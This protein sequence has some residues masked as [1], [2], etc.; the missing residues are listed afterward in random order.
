MESS[1]HLTPQPAERN[2][3]ETRPKKIGNTDFDRSGKRGEKAS[4][5]SPSYFLFLALSLYI[6]TPCF[7]IQYSMEQDAVNL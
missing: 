5:H 7:I 4:C 2:V 1:T 6:S 3:R